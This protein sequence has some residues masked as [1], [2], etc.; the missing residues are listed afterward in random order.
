MDK[1]KKIKLIVAICVFAVLLSIFIALLVLVCNGH[2]FAIDNLNDVFYNGRNSFWTGFFKIITHAG[3]VYFLVLVVLVM[4]MIT[5]K[6]Y[7]GLVG[8]ICLIGASIINLIVKYSVRRDRPIDVGLISEIGYSFPS[9]HAMLSMAIFGLI[10]YFVI[11]YGKSIALKITLTSLL[12]IMIILVGLSRV[13]LGVH[14]FSDVLSG[15]I[16]GAT[17]TLGMMIITRIIYHK[18]KKKQKLEKENLSN[19]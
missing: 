1:K 16:L 4:F 3:S 8:I 7:Y 15:W 10:I 18:R 17:F 11:K 12:S 6:K 19:N 13:Y 2:E 9:A 14:Y 5:R